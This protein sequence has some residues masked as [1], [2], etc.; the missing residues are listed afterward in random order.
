MVKSMFFPQTLSMTSDRDDHQPAGSLPSLPTTPRLYFHGLP[1]RAF[2]S[3][4]GLLP[5]L[6]TASLSQEYPE[7]PALFPLDCYPPGVPHTL[8]TCAKASLWMVPKS[9]SSGKAPFPHCNHVQSP[10]SNTFPIPH[11]LVSDHR[12]TFPGL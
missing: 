6:A 10:A 12:T 5:S 1:S 8:M 11:S 9:M 2:T 4:R 3:S 7:S